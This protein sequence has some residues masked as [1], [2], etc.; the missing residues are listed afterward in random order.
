[1]HLLF[2]KLK[3]FSILVVYSVEQVECME[4]VAKGLIKPDIHVADFKSLPQYL[5]DLTNGKLTGRIVFKP[6]EL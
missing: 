6:N 3:L 1:M 4:W 5:D 2:V